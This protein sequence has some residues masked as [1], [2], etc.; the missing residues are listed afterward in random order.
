[1]SEFQWYFPET[2]DEVIELLRE[3]G[4]APHGGGTGIIRGRLDRYKG[5]ICLDRLGLD[6][7]KIT[8]NEVEIGAMATYQDVIDKLKTDSEDCILVKSLQRAASTPL[9]NRIT[10][11][12]SVAYFPIWSDLMGPLIALKAEVELI[13]EHEG[14]YPIEKFAKDRSLKR[15]SLIR[16]VRF[17]KFKGLS[18]Y[19]R[20]ARTHFDYGA[21]NISLLT[22]SKDGKIS[23]F[24]LVLVGSR[25][26]FQTFEE[27]SDAVIGREPGEI[28]PSQLVNSIAD[29][30]QFHDTRIGS[31]EY[32]KAVALVEIERAIESTLKNLE[33]GK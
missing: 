27:L 28:E 8:D 23:D 15:G 11:G 5:L 20:V 13:G 19:Q 9:R 6:Y 10:I 16:S 3:P 32:T 22:N 25:Q 33:A 4:V 7:V 17:K 30:I 21:L 1:M 29:S 24:R 18:Y 26:K 14:V 2:L 31:G 12:G